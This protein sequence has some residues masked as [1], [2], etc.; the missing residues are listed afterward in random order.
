M[1]FRWS[2]SK[3]SASFLKLL[4]AILFLFYQMIAL[5]SLLFYLKSS[6]RS[7]D[8]QIFSLPVHNFWIQK[9]K[10]GIIYDVMNWL[11]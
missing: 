3:R 5:Q 8:I 1:V 7:P 9:N 11:A 10:S 6:F 4:S 2:K